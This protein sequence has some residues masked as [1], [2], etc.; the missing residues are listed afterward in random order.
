LTNNPKGA[1]I[2]TK[3]RHNNKHKGE[4]IMNYRV[5]NEKNWSERMGTYFHTYFKTKREAMAYA[6][7]IGGNAVVEKKVATTWVAY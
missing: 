5:Y 7:E 4:K 6:K 1:I 3:E 2:K